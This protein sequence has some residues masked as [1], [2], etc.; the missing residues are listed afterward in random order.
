[1]MFSMITKKD[2]DD[3]DDDDDDDGI[4]ITSVMKNSTYLARQNNLAC[5]NEMVLSNI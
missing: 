4:E 1:M 5:E 3:I 2:D